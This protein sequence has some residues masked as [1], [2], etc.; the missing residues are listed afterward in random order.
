MNFI[1]RN[2]QKLT[3]PEL[4]LRF[5]AV[6]HGVMLARINPT[7]EPPTPGP[8]EEGELLSSDADPTEIEKGLGLAPRENILRERRDVRPSISSDTVSQERPQ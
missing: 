7:E 2:L 5:W 8:G 4:E 3:P 1:L 6:P